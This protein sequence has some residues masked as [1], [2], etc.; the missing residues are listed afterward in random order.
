MFHIIPNRIGSNEWPMTD[1][2][3]TQH[4]TLSNDHL[5]LAC[6]DSD[7]K[8]IDFATVIHPDAV[9]RPDGVI[10]G[11]EQ[12][13]VPRSV[14]E[15][16]NRRR[17]LRSISAVLPEGT[18]EVDPRTN[19]LK[20]PA[21]PV[22]T[23]LPPVLPIFDAMAPGPSLAPALA[24]GPGDCTTTSTTKARCSFLRLEMNPQWS[25]KPPWPLSRI[26]NSMAFSKGLQQVYL[27]R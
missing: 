15:D 16:F 26:S 4:K 1:A 25:E 11:I 6:K 18:P 10:H 12:L 2:E 24:P 7:K 5:H 27:F 19:R 21:T 20:K 22:S 23:S 8:T 3:S 9:I 13:L 14:Q 17:N